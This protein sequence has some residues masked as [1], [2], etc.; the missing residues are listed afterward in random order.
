[1]RR[2]VAEG[3]AAVARDPE[4]GQVLQQLEHF[5]GWHPGGVGLVD[6]PQSAEYGRVRP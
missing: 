5:H 3:D 1:M 2:A 4:V 6:Q